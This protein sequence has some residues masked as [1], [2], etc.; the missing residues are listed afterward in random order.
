MAGVTAVGIIVVGGYFVREQARTE[1]AA[2]I[3]LGRRSDPEA[4]TRLLAYLKRH[5]GDADVV[6]V[7]V[8]WHLR[9]KTAFSE[10]EPHID[11]LCALRPGDPDPLRTRAAL[12]AWNGRPDE[13]VVDGL[14]A[15]EMAPDDHKTRRLV[16][17]AAAD[18]R[19]FDIAI[20]E[21]RRLLES[22]PFPKAEAG[23]MLVKAYLLAGD[24]QRAEQTLDDCFPA[25]QSG[26]DGTALRAQVFQAAGRHVEAA[27]LLRTLADK[28]PE[29]R[30]FA[31]FQLARSL[32]TLGREDDARKTLHEL[33]AWKA[34]TR[35]VVDAN[36][37]PDDMA[38]QL[39]AAEVLLADG[40]AGEAAALIERAIF[41]LG[42]DPAAAR[43]L[44]TAYRTLGRPDLAAE[45]ERAAER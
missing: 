11:R 7:L 23:T 45:W 9:A 31:L 10:V 34:R 36:Q 22:S 14:R 30:E 17:V 18:A 38:A 5:P 28:S 1:R 27:A 15:L 42:K 3:R 44:A 2:V 39:R 6:E 43:V 41:R 40:K 37:R 8:A 33:E 19:Q 20:R 24:V 35:L 12:R 26:M 21:A 16:A 29:Y 25:S 32:T 13:A 4:A